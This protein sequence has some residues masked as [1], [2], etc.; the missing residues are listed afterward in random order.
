MK[1]DLIIK[2]IKTIVIGDLGVGKSSLLNR[3]LYNNFDNNEPSTIGV[4][5][6]THIFKR[7]DLMVK[8]QFWDVA[9]QERF[10]SI[11]N[12]YLRGAKCVVIVY[13]ITDRK[14]FLNLDYWL[15]Y[16]SENIDPSQYLL[17]I[18]IGSKLD[19]NN[20][21]SISLDEIDL[22][23]QKN[24]LTYFE[25]SSKFDDSSITDV[26][27]KIIDIIY[28]DIKNN[29]IEFIKH[30]EVVLSQPIPKTYCC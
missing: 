15:D 22:F 1:T 7:E 2:I 8:C 16:I 9:G 23:V 24:N 17:R 27:N 6:F 11:V 5:F 13:D 19:L 18:L 3:L 12:L 25:V 28:K 4:Q 10:R 14:S 20:H 29:K 21:R 26:F 30:Q